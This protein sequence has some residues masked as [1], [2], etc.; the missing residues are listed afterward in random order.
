MRS[1]CRMS[2]AKPSYCLLL[3]QPCRL[4]LP[5]GFLLRLQVKLPP[6]LKPVFQ[7]TFVCFCWSVGRILTCK[8]FFLVDKKGTPKRRRS[9][10]AGDES[11]SS[12]P[13]PPSAVH[14]GGGSGKSGKSTP[15]GP[16]GV[17]GGTPRLHTPLSERQQMQMLMQLTA[18]DE[19]PANGRVHN[20]SRDCARL[21]LGTYACLSGICA[22]RLT[23]QGGGKIRL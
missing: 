9:I 14:A 7:A 17:G 19:H 20:V 4:K 6:K 12:T 23:T 2:L 13:P 21:I 8:T 15:G 22:T 16:S 10:L 11:S 18:A 1:C 5:I 3:I